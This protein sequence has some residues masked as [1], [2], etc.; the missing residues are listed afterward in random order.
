MSA[1]TLRQFLRMDEDERHE[2]SVMH[3]DRHAAFSKDVRIQM[4]KGEGDVRT[5]LQ[6][7]VDNP[8]VPDDNR[9]KQASVFTLVSL[10]SDVAVARAH[11]T[12]LSVCR[13]VQAL[14]EM[15]SAGK[16][17]QLEQQLHA[18][19]QP[20]LFIGATPAT[21]FRIATLVNNEIAEHGHRYCTGRMRHNISAMARPFL[22]QWFAEHPADVFT[23]RARQEIISATLQLHQQEHQKVRHSIRLLLDQHA[24]SASAVSVL[25]SVAEESSE[26]GSS[27]APSLIAGVAGARIHESSAAAPADVLIR[28]QHAQLDTIEQQQ[29]RARE[30]ELANL[31]ARI[32]QMEEAEQARAAADAQQQARINAGAL[33]EQQRILQEAQQQEMKMQSIRQRYAQRNQEQLHVPANMPH[34]AGPQ[35]GASPAANV[36]GTYGDFKQFMLSSNPAAQRFQSRL[37]SPLQQQVDA[38]RAERDR[39]CGVLHPDDPIAVELVREAHARFAK[40][41]G[42]KLFDK[43]RQKMID[44]R[45]QLAA[46]EDLL[47]TLL[48][49]IA[50][51]RINCAL[52]RAQVDIDN[53]ARSEGKDERTERTTRWEEEA[54]R[55][56]RAREEKLAREEA[57]T[58][59]TRQAV[60]LSSYMNEFLPAHMRPAAAPGP[61]YGAY[62]RGASGPGSISSS[63]YGAAAALQRDNED[64]EDDVDEDDV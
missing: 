26:A 15:D 5:R 48:E 11:T 7:L 36:T 1:P 8:T 60:Q 44:L 16:L 21:P 25:S 51:L 14:E 32:R 35:F 2:F 53:V 56:Q 50:E 23:A 39:L 55:R 3:P 13:A 37:V 46:K 45:K 43:R 4:S 52:Y 42:K 34:P 28:Q 33:A 58:K 10:H 38:L 24:H 61:S 54:A 27:V 47:G 59:K 63:N 17:T 41:G 18:L 20:P 22:E 12:V 9:A 19:L 57:K 6:A 31:Q 30:E 49:E 29:A 40:P 62:P 64:M